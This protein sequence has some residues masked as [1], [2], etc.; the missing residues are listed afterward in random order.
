MSQIAY[1]TENLHS[2]RFLDIN[3][4]AKSVVLY[5]LRI[6]KLLKVQSRYTLTIFAKQT[7][8][9][10]GNDIICPIKYAAWV[11]RT[12]PK[13]KN[14]VFYKEADIALCASVLVLGVLLC[15]RNILS[16]LLT[17]LLLTSQ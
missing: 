8:R 16:D 1:K 13:T 11:S 6:N 15:C 2:Q 7:V 10:T 12:E 4:R 17:G 5:F 3:Q 9:I 14:L